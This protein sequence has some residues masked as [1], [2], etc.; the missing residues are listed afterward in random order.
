MSEVTFH[1][2]NYRLFPYERRLAQREIESLLAV[3]PRRFSGGLRADVA[4]PPNGE[5]ARLTYFSE[6]E[7]PGTVYQPLQARLEHASLLATGPTLKRQSTRY[8]AHGLH[9]YKG[10]FNPQIVRATGNVLRLSEGSWIFD[11][12][13]G[14]GTTLL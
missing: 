14:S 2:P 5:L 9:E 6:V 8:S 1:W 3:V 7:L 11:P 10:K 12:F 13:C 4:L